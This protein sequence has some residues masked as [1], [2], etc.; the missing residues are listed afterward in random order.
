MAKQLCVTFRYCTKLLIFRATMTPSC[1]TNQRD[2]REDK[3]PPSIT[4]EH[5]ADVWN[6][7]TAAGR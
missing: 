4:A 1:N 5:A 6:Q 3:R 7:Q 2:T